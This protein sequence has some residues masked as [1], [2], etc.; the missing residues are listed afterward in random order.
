MFGMFV[1][2]A[3]FMLV[4]CKQTL[5]INK[6]DYSQP[7]ETV[8]EPNAE[9]Q[10]TDVRNNI[11]FNILPLQYKETKDTTS[12]TTKEIR[13]IRGKEGFYY[14]TAPG[15]Q[16]VY[17]MAPEK[18]SL[19][20]QKQ[21]QINKEGLKEPAFN[22]RNPYVQLLNKSTGETYALTKEGIAKP[23]SNKQEGGK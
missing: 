1:L 2:I 13:M 10:V 16:H 9:G 18:G 19:K 22:Q 8:L 14:M 6:V 11:S 21:V 5:V 3:G 12:V 4:G 7:V 17:V 20:L 23:K 15:F